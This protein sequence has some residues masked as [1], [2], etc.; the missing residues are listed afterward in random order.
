M[1]KVSCH[2]C[3]EY[4]SFLPPRLRTSNP[5]T[6]KWISIVHNNVRSVASWLIN[7]RHDHSHI[8]IHKDLLTEA[9][10]WVVLQAVVIVYPT[11]ATFHLKQNSL[12]FFRFPVP[13]KCWGFFDDT[14][15][16][17]GVKSISIRAVMHAFFYICDLRVAGVGWSWREWRSLSCMVLS[18]QTS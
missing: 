13:L 9:Q 6:M 15:G 17:G 11:L 12:K 10:T 16:D 14:D 5:T 1:R 3:N 18:K 7:T 8:M 4:L 2:Y